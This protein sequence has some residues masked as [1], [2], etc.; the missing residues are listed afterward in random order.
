MS[1]TFWFFFK[2]LAIHLSESVL[3]YCAL[4]C[5]SI[6]PTNGFMPINSLGSVPMASVC[7]FSTCSLLIYSTLFI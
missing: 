2:L 6:E 4:S 3:A 5:T 7:S 1:V